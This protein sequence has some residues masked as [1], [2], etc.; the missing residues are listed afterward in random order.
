MNLFTIIYNGLSEPFPTLHAKRMDFFNEGVVSLVTY[1]LLTFTDALP[2]KQAQYLMGWLF[3]FC[4]VFMLGTNSFF[5]VRG[6]IRNLYLSYLK[7][8]YAKQQKLTIAKKL[9]RIALEPVPDRVLKRSLPFK[10][11]K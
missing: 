7:S 9:E 6:T 5:V 3:V 1:L 11:Q 10:E 2:N 8:S 4:L